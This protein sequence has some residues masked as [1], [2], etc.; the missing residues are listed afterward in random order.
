[1]YAITALN[2]FQRYKHKSCS[3]ENTDY[4]DEPGSFFSKEQFLIANGIS[5][6]AFYTPY[7]VIYADYAEQVPFY[8]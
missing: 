8:S 5:I 4:R 7:P 6:K 2:A 3:G 1:M